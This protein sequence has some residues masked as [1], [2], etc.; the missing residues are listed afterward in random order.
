MLYG[1]KPSD[2]ASMAI[3]LAGVLLMA[4]A[5]SLIPASR[6]ARVDPLTALRME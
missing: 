4:V 3:A 5:A 2:F 1:L 6:A